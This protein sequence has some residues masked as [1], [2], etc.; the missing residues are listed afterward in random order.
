MVRVID[1]LWLAPPDA[2]VAV[3][4]TF[5]VPAGVLCVG[6][7]V[8]GGVLEEEPPQPEIPAASAPVIS[9]SRQ[10][11]NIRCRVFERFFLRPKA[12]S[13]AMLPGHQKA[14]AGRIGLSGLG[15]DPNGLGTACIRAI[16]GAVATLVSMLSGTVIA[17]LP[18]IVTTWL[19][20]PAFCEKAQYALT[21][22]PAQT[23]VSLPV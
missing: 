22:R 6:I 1:T 13:P 20:A 21:G 3:T 14:S 10:S 5:D 18:L 8:A 17:A 11:C 7:V 16:G 4:I 9:T 23:S 15:C 2:G 12:A 19:C